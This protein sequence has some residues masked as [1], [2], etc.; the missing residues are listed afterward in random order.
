ML[1]R[2]HS[3]RVT[4]VVGINS[5]MSYLDLGADPSEASSFMVWLESGLGDW[6]TSVLLSDVGNFEVIAELL[7]TAERLAWCQLFPDSSAFFVP[8]SDSGQGSSSR[9][10]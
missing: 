5:V 7:R 10:L 8:S 3:R 2:V 4:S 6:R 1:A 9:L